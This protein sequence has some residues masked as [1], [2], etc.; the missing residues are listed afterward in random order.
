MW[1]WAAIL[2]VLVVLFTSSIFIFRFIRCKHDSWEEISRKFLI[3]FIKI[4]LT[5]AKSKIWPGN[6]ASYTRRGYKKQFLSSCILYY[7]VSSTIFASDEFHYLLTWCLV[8][9]SSWLARSLHVPHPSHSR[10]Q[11]TMQLKSSLHLASAAPSIGVRAGW[12]LRELQLKLCD[13]SGKMLMFG[14]R[15]GE[16]TLQNSDVGV[17]IV[18]EVSI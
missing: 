18:N 11:T 17:N 10:T 1:L 14:R 8:L 4:N 12:A 5:T 3:N 9:S 2:C 15:H 16:K 7:C 13:F 6:Q